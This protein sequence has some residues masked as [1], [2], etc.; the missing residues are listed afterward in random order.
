[1]MMNPVSRLLH[2]EDG[3][4]RT[5]KT[6][7]WTGALSPCKSLATLAPYLRPKTTKTQSFVTKLALSEWQ[8]TWLS[9]ARIAEEC[10]SSG[11]VFA[12]CL[13][14]P[15]RSLDPFLHI[16]INS[17]LGPRCTQNTLKHTMI[18]GILEVLNCGTSHD[19][20]TTLVL[21]TQ[22]V[23]FALSLPLSH[24]QQTNVA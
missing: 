10:L 22:H 9:Y 2:N 20:T 15:V 8:G 5:N 1:M 19:F 18:W 13:L 14:L 24:S 16:F 17:I 23:P 7:S 12:D 21:R 11:A 3:I 6:F 4:I